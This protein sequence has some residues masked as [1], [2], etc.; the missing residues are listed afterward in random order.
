MIYMTYSVTHP[1]N[2]KMGHEKFR[3][4]RLTGSLTI[5]HLAESGNKK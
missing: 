3:E 2:C 5:V 4:S 1:E